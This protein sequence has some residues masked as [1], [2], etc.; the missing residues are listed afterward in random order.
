MPGFPCVVG[1][2][3]GVGG[4]DDGCRD[5]PPPVED[6][7]AVGAVPCPVSFDGLDG[8]SDF[9]AHFADEGLLL[10]FAGFDGASGEAPCAWCADVHGAA[11]GEESVAVVADDGDYADE[12]CG[13]AWE[14]F[15]CTV[16]L[17]VG[18]FCGRGVVMVVLERTG[19]L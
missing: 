6:E 8:E 14:C 2:F 18:V 16:A 17:P 15:G 1:D 7:Q 19:G 13:R 10:C 4:D 9:F 5:G 3:G 12:R 11:D